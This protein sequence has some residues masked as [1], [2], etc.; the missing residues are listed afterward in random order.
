MS[1]FSTRYNS[2]SLT[3]L[4][5]STL[6]RYNQFNWPSSRK[7]AGVGTV[8]YKNVKT[9]LNSWLWKP[10]P[11][12]LKLKIGE[13]EHWGQIQCLALIFFSMGNS[14]TSMGR[15]E[16]R[17]TKDCQCSLLTFHLG[18]ALYFQSVAGP[19]YSL[20]ST[21]W[22][23]PGGSTVPLQGKKFLFS[24]LYQK[25]LYQNLNTKQTSS[26]ELWCSPD[27]CSAVK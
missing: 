4:I 10:A 22:Q 25:S 3:S 9:H 20:E 11:S 2:F 12:T 26:T 1:F 18:P 7:A 24:T 17:L 15:E 23:F 6:C 16:S 14:W 27:T 13:S 21:A 8:T 19:L 5:H